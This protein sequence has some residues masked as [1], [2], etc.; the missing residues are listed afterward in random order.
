MN[1]KKCVSGCQSFDGGEKKHHKDCPFYPQSLSKKYD[2]LEKE[3]Q[4]LRE[5]IKGIKKLWDNP[6]RDDYT[7]NGFY[8]KIKEILK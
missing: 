3:N 8:K 4:K 2:D 5:I 6:D 7:H 1:K